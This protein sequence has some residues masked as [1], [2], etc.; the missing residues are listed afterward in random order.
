MRTNNKTITTSAMLIL[1][2]G[3]LS[4]PALAQHE[5]TIHVGKKGQL[6]FSS[7]TRVGDAIIPKGIYQFQHVVEGADHVVVFKKTTTGKEVAR[8][9]CKIEPLG[10]KAKGTLIY[11][12]AEGG[13]HVT[14]IVVAGENVKHVF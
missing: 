14:Q 9:K 5:G 12:S 4:L 3:L 2:L 7:D 11:T 1:A 13:A 6:T 10:E 8:V